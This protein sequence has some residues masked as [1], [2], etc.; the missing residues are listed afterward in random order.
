MNF[1]LPE[2]SI[3]TIMPLNTLFCNFGG[4]L[5]TRALFGRA[6]GRF[7]NIKALILL[8]GKLKNDHWRISNTNVQYVY[9]E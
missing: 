1:F 9:I 4:R 6:R 3:S 2:F 7:V 5:R 8:H